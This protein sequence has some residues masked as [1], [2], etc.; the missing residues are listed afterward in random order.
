MRVDRDGNIPAT[1]PLV[2][3]A[4]VA[5]CGTQFTCSVVNGAGMEPTQGNRGAPRTEIY[6]W[7]LRNPWRFTFDSQ[8]GYMW[9]GD[10]G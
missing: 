8:T 2:G 1:N 3:V 6:L 4:D 7:G 5:A 10:V 9:I